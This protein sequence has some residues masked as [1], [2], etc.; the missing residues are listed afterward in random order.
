M[1]WNERNLF[2][3]NSKGVVD[4]VDS[5]LIDFLTSL[6]LVLGASGS[7]SSL[8]GSIDFVSTDMIYFL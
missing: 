8:D 4:I 6:L 2:I 7:S 5:G 1:M 3:Q